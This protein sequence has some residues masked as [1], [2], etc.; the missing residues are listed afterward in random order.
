M[1]IFESLKQIE[2]FPDPV[3]T[4]GNYD[5]IH[6]G[7]K[8]IIEKVRDNARRI[9]G[10]PMLMTFYPHPVSVVKP[11]KILCLITP[12]SVRKRLIEESGIEALF[13]LPFDE[14][15]RLQTPD[16]FVKNI[17]VDKLGIKGLIVGYDFKFG[18]GGKGDTALLDKLSVEYGFFFEVVEAITVNGEKIGSNRIRKLI[19]EG[20]VKK[21]GLFLGRHFNIEGKVVHG[22]GRGRGMGFPTVNLKTDYELIPKEGVYVSEVEING[23]KFPSVTNVGYNPTFNTGRLSIETHILDYSRDLYEA[24]LNVIFHDR[25]RGEIKFDGVDALKDGIAADVDIA[26]MY[27]RNNK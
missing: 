18:Q 2:K 6:T 25:I 7:H 21:A 4:I 13:I 3:L 19:M 16:E 10:T 26:R 24:D 17:L 23:K 9:N 14:E 1:K 27:F 22:D 5:G 11:D 8:S 15:F 20:D 12:F